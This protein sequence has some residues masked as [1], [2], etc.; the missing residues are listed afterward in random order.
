MYCAG[1]SWI[2]INFQGSHHTADLHVT[3][4]LTVE[5]V[6]NRWPFDTGLYTQILSR[7]LLYTGAQ[8]SRFYWRNIKKIML[9]QLSIIS[10][11]YLHTYTHTHM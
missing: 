4:D 11:R 3:T 8:Y 1:H 6:I 9:L 5:A 7:G 2:A 10:E